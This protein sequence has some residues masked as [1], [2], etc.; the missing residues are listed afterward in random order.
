[1]FLIKNDVDLLNECKFLKNDIF[2]LTL[3]L[4]KILMEQNEEYLDYINNEKE[5]IIEKL[6]NKWKH[7]S[8]ICLKMLEMNV[9]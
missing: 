6:L 3:E 4:K 1:M 9:Q 2:R 8:Q 7:I 5:S